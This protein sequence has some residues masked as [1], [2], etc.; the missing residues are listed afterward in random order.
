[1]ST[2][3]ND[4]C[5]N[6]LPSITSNSIDLI[7]TDPPYGTTALD[8][9]SIIPFESMWS[10]LNRIIKPNGAIILFGIEPFTSL[11]R[12]S[13]L[14]S[15]KYDWYWVKERLTNIQQVKRRPGKTV[16]TI[17]VFYNKQ[18]TY[19]P[20][21]TIYDGP[22]RSNK[23]KNGKLGKLT[24][25]GNKKV[26]EYKDTGLRYPTQILN[27]K[28]DI[29]TSNLHPTQKPVKLL[30]YLIKTY[31]NENDMVLDF[32]MGSG[33]TGVAAKNL[34]R[35]FIGIEKDVNYFNIASDRIYGN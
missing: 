34:N 16:E 30:E 10:E 1:M 33:S 4:D 18:P 3:F 2:I 9:D 8:W 11:L 32:T 12:C 17:S 13:N 19:N 15:Y 20:Q 35:R 14:K 7:L 29:L 28:R 22:I 5:L 25:D 31:S 26:T 27:F 23:V 21:M 6:I 24:D